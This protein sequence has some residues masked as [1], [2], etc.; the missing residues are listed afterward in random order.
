MNAMTPFESGVKSS[1]EFLFNVKGLNVSY[2]VHNLPPMVV[3]R[4]ANLDVLKGRAHL[5]VGPNGCGKTTLLRA[6]MGMLPRES[7]VN[8]QYVHWPG[9]HYTDGAGLV[10]RLKVGY[11]PQHPHEAII[12]TFTVRENVSFRGHLITANSLLKWMSRNVGSHQ[13]QQAVADFM[14]AHEPARSLFAHR[15]DSAVTMLS[16]GEQQVLLLM[17]MRFLQADLVVMD[18]PTS[19]LDQ[20]NRE[21]FWQYC[22]QLTMSK[23]MTLLIVTHD[24]IRAYGGSCSRVFD[25][26][27]FSIRE[28]NFDVDETS[29][30]G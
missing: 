10:K 29:A 3:L 7:Q 17:A 14:N 25:F 19:K 16:G 20:D 26:H 5:L 8:S 27:D 13:S 22:R 4:N 6:I 9:G 30:K 15:L 11:I 2:P 18:E 23:D 12:P 21:L 24:D 28:R 1:A